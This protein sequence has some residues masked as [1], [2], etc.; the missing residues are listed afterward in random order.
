VGGC[1]RRGKAYMKLL[2]L[3]VALLLVVL[4][5]HRVAQVRP[6]RPQR[7]L[8]NREAKEAAFEARQTERLLGVA[9][10]DFPGPQ[11]LIG[12]DDLPANT[13]ALRFNINERSPTGPRPRPNYEP[14][15]IIEAQAPDG[16]I[17]EAYS[18]RDEHE[19]VQEHGFVSTPDNTR[20]IYGTHHGYAYNPQD[21]YI[22]KRVAG[23]LKPTLFFRDV[24][25]HNTAPHHFAI[26]NKGM[27]HL[28]VA[29]VNIFQ[30]NRLDLYW[31][32]GD[33][34]SGKWTAAWRIDRRGFTS[35]SYPWSA[36]WG[37]KVNVLWNWC[38]ESVHKNAPGMGIFYLQWGPSGFGRKVRVVQGVP[39]T[40]D[41][42]IDPQSGRLLLVYAKAD[43]V[44]ITSRLE[45]GSWTRP[46]LLSSKLGY[47][48]ALSVKSADEGTFIIRIGD[49]DTREWLLRPLTR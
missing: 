46:S 37:D 2:Y 1:V 23:R 44:Y 19:L 31:V 30:D 35:W 42:A 20:Q 49:E 28:I 18:G 26:D 22:G 8:Q 3:I 15:P 43:G 13:P 33:L 45:R 5:V 12:F 39:R 24:G 16:T 6:G 10:R 38:D 48:L 32:V 34:L 29:D 9:V 47:V 7:E 21:V 40:W 17:Y 25:S 14:R 27:A 41:A 11:G 4:P 36:A